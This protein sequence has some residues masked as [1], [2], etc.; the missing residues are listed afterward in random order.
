MTITLIGGSGFVGTRL[1]KRL[2]AA[3][4]TVKI[5][6]KRKSV[7]YLELWLRCDVRNRGDETN[8]FPASLTDEAAA[9][10]ADE[11]ARKSQPMHSLLDVLR[12]SDTVINLSAEHRDDVTPKSLYDDVNVR[13]SENICDA[14]TRLE[15]RR[16]IFTSS[17]AVYGFAP[18][19]T[20]ESGEINYFNDYGRTKFFAEEKYCEWLKSDSANSAVIIRPTVIFGEQNRGNVY[21][22]LRQIAGGKFPMVGRGTNRKSMNYVENVAAFIQFCVENEEKLPCFE[23]GF[24]GTDAGKQHLFNCCD[25]PAYDMNTLVLDVYRFLGKPKTHLVHFPY[26]LAYLCGKCFDLAAFIMHRKFAVSSIR[27]KKFCQNTYFT[28]VRV[29]RTGFVPPVRLEDGLKAT[30]EYEFVNKVE[31]H[32]FSCE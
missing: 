29:P 20:D 14:C 12:G 31:G 16:I 9:P 22:L 3:G 2:L 32:T 19:G 8:E 7:A 6:D 25:E 17:V 15:I 4:H 28:S 11:A 24:D 5:A 23:K 10:G 30:V 26:R 27:V 18:V 21:N 13:G 1:A